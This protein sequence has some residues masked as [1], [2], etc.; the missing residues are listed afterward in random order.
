MSKECSVGGCSKEAK[1]KGM[2]YSHYYR[3][4][5]YGDP[6]AKGVMNLRGEYSEHPREYRCWDHMKQRCCNPKNEAYRL[7][8]GRGIKVCERWIEK[9]DGF[10]NFLQDMGERPEGCSL[11]RIDVNGDYTP[12][13]CRWANQSIQAYNQQSREHSTKYT[14]ISVSRYVNGSP[15]FVANITK[16]YKLYRKE[17]DDIMD[18][19]IWRAEKEVEFFG[20]ESLSPDKQIAL[21]VKWGRERKI[22]NIEKQFAKVVEEVAEIAREIVRGRYDSN[23]IFDAIGDSLVTLVILSDLVKINPIDTFYEAYNEIK[24]RK[25]KTVDG[26]FVKEEQA[27]VQQPES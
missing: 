11:D 10:H 20:E 6:L 3:L 4:R 22:N 9:P 1:Q 2:C 14:G 15:I 21:I 7:Y 17:F 5:Q 18:A 25:G 16:D 12:D 8:G 27:E 13:N 23:E 26:T 24:D 19:L